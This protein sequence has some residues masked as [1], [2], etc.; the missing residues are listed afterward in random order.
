MKSQADSPVVNR[1]IVGLDGRQG[2]R[3]QPQ[4]GRL[5]FARSPLSAGR[6]FPLPLFRIALFLPTAPDCCGPE[7]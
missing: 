6:T 4:C 1:I 5:R 2:V 7:R 3:Y